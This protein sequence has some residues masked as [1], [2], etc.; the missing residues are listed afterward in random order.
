[1]SRGRPRTFDLENAIEQ[2]ML[3]FWK[4]GFDA[5]SLRDLTNALGISRPSLY[6]A[7]GSKEGLFKLALDRYRQGPAWYVNRAIAEN[8]AA[9]V[10]RSLLYGVIDLVTDPDRPGGCLFV[11]GSIAPG[12]YEDPIQE[13][14]A[15]RRIE[16]EADI[17]RRFE[18]A[19][20]AGD[21]PPASDPSTLARLATTLIWGLSVQASN[22]AAKPE[23]IEVADLAIGAFPS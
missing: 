4:K 12:R 20:A 22:G 17:R 15:K 7:F 8:T 18:I 21:L 23:L 13:E 2:A 5:T 19:K 10:F 6:A 3:L 14:L 11:C 9:M 16:G 1:M